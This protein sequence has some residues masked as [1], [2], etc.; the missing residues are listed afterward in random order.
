MPNAYAKLTDFGSILFERTKLRRSILV[1]Y[2]AVV[3]LG[4]PLW[5]A[6]T[7]I[8]R[9]TLPAAHFESQVNNTVRGNY[10][11][12]NLYTELFTARSTNYH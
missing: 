4:V 5:L 7:S 3:L 8:E 6:T 1:S 11:Y 10:V 2:W 9:L 12:S